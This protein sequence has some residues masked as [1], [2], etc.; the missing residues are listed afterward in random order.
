MRARNTDPQEKHPRRAFPSG[1]VIAAEFGLYATLATAPHQVVP[2]SS[3]ERCPVVLL[4]P[5]GYGILDSSTVRVAY[6]RQDGALHLR[7]IER[8]QD[9]GGTPPEPKPCTM[10]CN[11]P[12][13][14][15]EVHTRPPSVVT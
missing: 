10:H 14:F 11:D 15:V 3:L 6:G 2:G 1:G 8:D 5:W 13:G 12:K 9:D 7:P 4:F